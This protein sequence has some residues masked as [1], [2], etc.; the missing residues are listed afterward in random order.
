MSVLG[1]RRSDSGTAGVVST[2]LLS[3]RLSVLGVT[4]SAGVSADGGDKGDVGDRCSSGTCWLTSEPSL[5]LM[6]GLDGDF[7]CTTGI[8]TSSSNNANKSFLYLG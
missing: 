1:V 4:G 3:D 8:T 7:F 6:E 5:L 2:S